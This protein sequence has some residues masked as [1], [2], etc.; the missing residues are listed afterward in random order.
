MMTAVTPDNLA[1]LLGDQESPCLSLYQP[2]HRRHP[3]NLQDPIRYSNLLKIL[4]E[5]LLQKYGMRETTPFLEPFR[6]LT[7]DRDFWNHTLDGLAVLGAPG[8]FEVFRLQRPVP[9]LAIAADSFHIKPLVRIVQSADRYQV[10]SVNQREIRLFQGNRDVLDEIELSEGVP[11]TLTEAL[12][13]QLSDPRLTVSSYGTGPG[14]P[15]PA[16]AGP[17]MRH[18]HGG[19]K[20][21]VDIDRERFF[22]AVDRGIAEHHSRPTGLPLILAALPEHHGH[23]HDVSQNP[24]LLPDGIKIDPEALT[25]D[26]LREKA[27]QVMEPSYRARLAQLVDQFHVAR[28]RALA[29]GDL[30]D[31]AVAAVN[32]RVATLL[33]EGDRHVG[34]RLDPV[35]GRVSL[36]DIVD[37]EV[38]DVLD[39]VAERTLRTSGEVI[40]VPPSGMPTDTGLAAIYRY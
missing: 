14:G 29:S 40:V 19:K 37:P 13:D 28:A 8:R 11:R 33:V 26:E 2:T 34:G 20:D 15:G 32:G 3:E 25:L 22:R 36:D 12:G 1:Q 21:E 24:L 30:S 39:D 27:W 31:I 17:G 18:G 4:E 10:L 6:L 23:F 5:S 35:S 38:D 16:H 9:E 7:E